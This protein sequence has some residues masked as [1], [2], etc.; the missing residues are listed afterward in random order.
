MVVIGGGVIGLFSAYYAAREGLDVVVL[1]SE[2]EDHW[3]CSMGNAGMLVPSHFTPLAAPGMVAYGLQQILQPGGPF[4]VKLSPDLLRWAALFASASKPARCNAAKPLLAKLNLASLEE[5]SEL[6]SELGDFG[7]SRT[8]LLMLCKSPHALSE[9]AKLAREARQLGMEAHVLTRQGVQDLNPGIET[10]VEGGVF[11]PQD[12]HL[13]TGE[14][15][16]FLRRKVREMGVSLEFGQLVTAAEFRHQKLSS[17][18]CGTQ[19]WE[20]EQFVLA[21]GSL[22]QHLARLFELRV[23]VIAG[24]GYSFDLESPPQSPKICSILVEGRVA[25]TPMRHALRI[26]G[27]MELGAKDLSVDPRRIVGIRRAVAQYYPALA[28]ASTETAKVWAGLRPCS[29]DGLPYLGRPARVQNLIVATGHA[30]MGLSLA[31]I[32]GRIVSELL[33]Q[34]RTLIDLKALSPDRYA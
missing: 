9:E 6:T 32:T 17:V 8:G 7:L 23:P 31:P 13:T 26:A 2:S 4:G 10:D 5:Y 19:E 11:F 3:N 1:E 21:A 25:V 20:A 27:T 12:G 29:P 33:T 15:L 16:T 14:L 28:L 22:S 24:K 18:V 34:K 30:M